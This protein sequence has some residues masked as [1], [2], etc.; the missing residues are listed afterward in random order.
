MNYSDGQNRKFILVQLPEKCEERSEAYRNGYKDI[1]QIGE[2]RIRRAGESILQDFAEKTAQIEIG[3]IVPSDPDIGFK[4]FMLDKSSFYEWN[5]SGDESLFEGTIREDRSEEDVL[6]EVMLKWGLELSLPVERIVIADYEM[7]SV[8]KNALICCM[9]E[10][11]TVE[12]LEAI[13]DLHPDRVLLLDSILNDSLKL[14]AAHILGTEKL[15][16]V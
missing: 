10:D 13:R 8:A 14:N 7:Y 3:G 16:T 15:R 9:K 11:L 1:C 5:E 4:V 12:V 2:D 6:Y